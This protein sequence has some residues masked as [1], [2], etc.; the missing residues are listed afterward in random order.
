MPEVSSAAARVARAAKARDS[1]AEVDARRALAE[2]KIHDK[3][4]TTSE[5]SWRKL[6]R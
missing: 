2:A 6:H 4:M 5:R 3:S 1:E